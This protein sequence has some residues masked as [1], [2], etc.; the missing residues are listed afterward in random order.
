MHKP[1]LLFIALIAAVA[2]PLSGRAQ[3]AYPATLAGHAVLPA[4]SMIAAPKDAPVD[5]QT[6]GKFTTVKRVE[7]LGSVEG[8]SAGR[9]TGISLPFKG[10]HLQGI[11][12]SNA[13]P[14]AAIGC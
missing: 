3:Q 6:S 13:W 12:E 8:L 7:K 5:L 2:L 14:T 10:Q 4:N 1:T 11:P 9:P